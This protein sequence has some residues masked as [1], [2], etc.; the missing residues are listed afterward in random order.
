MSLFGKIKN[1][2][3]SLRKDWRTDV[4]FSRK[5]AFLRV[6]DNIY[7]KLGLKNASEKAFKR[8][9]AILVD[10]L[11]KQLKSVIAKYRSTDN[12][13]FYSEKAPIWVCWWAGIETAPKIVQQCVKSIFANSNNRDV[14][15]ITK[16]NYN[17]F[18]KVPDF[19]L[20]KLNSQ[21]IGFAHFA[22]YLRVS[23]LEKYGGL[24]LD[25]TIFCSK[26]IPDNIFEFPLYTLKSKYCENTR[27]TSKY[28]WVTFCLGGW[29]GNIFYSFL[30]EAF[31]VYWSQNEYAIDYL[32]FDYIIDL[33]RKNI[34]SI[35][36]NMDKIP[37]NTPHRDDLQA[38]MNAQLPAED[39]EKIIKDDTGLY[40]LSWRE[41]YSEVTTDGK[42][43]VYGYFINSLKI[44]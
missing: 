14:Y 7:S 24:W 17:Q 16:D 30:K 28:Q 13:G 35:K 42:E 15:L 44:G 4:T 9:E 40:K 23:L 11:E 1:Y 27:Y 32:F 18:V 43:S 38:A 3:F 39:F 31:E 2:Y 10:Y 37:I 21:K 33:A 25:A 29:R 34:P 22:D 8:R 12:I 5:Y 26:E 20:E 36:K 6:K 19:F 41:S